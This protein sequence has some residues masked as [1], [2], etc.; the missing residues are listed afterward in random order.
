MGVGY[1]YESRLSPFQPFENFGCFRGCVYHNTFACCAAGYDVAIV[2][3]G[4]NDELID[5]KAV[6]LYYQCHY[7]LRVMSS[8][9]IVSKEEKLHKQETKSTH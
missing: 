7:D 9:K 1:Q 8:E 4:P 3:E 5:L 2:V 6:I